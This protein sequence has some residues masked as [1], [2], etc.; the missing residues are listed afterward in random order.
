M[1]NWLSL[2]VVLLLIPFQTIGRNGP[3]TVIFAQPP[4][5]PPDAY[6]GFIILRLSP[7]RFGTLVTQTDDLR[8]LAKR[9]DAKD[10]LSVLD[11]CPQCSATRV[12]SR[13]TTTQILEME[14]KAAQ[15]RGQQPSLTLYW[16]L[17]VRKY[18]D[19]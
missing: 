15:A 8:E 12:L 5:P 2:A 13:W 9:A 6:S 18:A 16:K 7:P 11:Q 10:L 14:R 1:R 19:P 3:S 4:E 17:D